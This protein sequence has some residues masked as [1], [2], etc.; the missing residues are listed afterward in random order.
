MGPPAKSFP[1]EGPG[2]PPSAE[3]N[4]CFY[5]LIIVAQYSPLSVMFPVGTDSTPGIKF[6]LSQDSEF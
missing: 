2:F 3:G 6:S 4:S 1:V 5:L